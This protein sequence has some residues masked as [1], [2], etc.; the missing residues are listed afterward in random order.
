MVANF[1]ARMCATI[2]VGFTDYI[3]RGCSPNDNAAISYCTYCRE[4]VI[5]RRYIVVLHYVAVGKCP[6]G[7]PGHE[8]DFK[9]K[10]RTRLLHK[11]DVESHD[12]K[13]S[14]FK[15]FIATRS[16]ASLLH[17]CSSSQCL[18]LKVP[19][20]ILAEVSCRYYSHYQACLVASS[21]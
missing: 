16:S 17:S 15:I 19:L 11:H 13:P 18:S 20:I 1:H 5:D 2:F 6:T 8:D 14:I 21:K 12:N 7:I 10:S 9:V 4:H 3:Y